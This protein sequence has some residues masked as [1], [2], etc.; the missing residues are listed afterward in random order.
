MFEKIKAKFIRSIARE[1]EQTSGIEQL[2]ILSGIKEEE[3]IV[4]KIR[5]ARARLAKLNGQIERLEEKKELAEKIDDVPGAWLLRLRDK[6]EDELIM[7]ERNQVEA[8]RKAA[9]EKFNL[10]NLILN[11]AK[12]NRGKNS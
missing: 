10:I 5:K 6:V 1:I 7:A 2:S 3:R 8:D 12:G 4:I 11:Y 9:Q